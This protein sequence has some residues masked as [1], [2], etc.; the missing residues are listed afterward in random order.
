MLP[1]CE[2]KTLREYCHEVLQTLEAESSDPL[3]SLMKS[4]EFL[5]KILNVFKRINGSVG[6]VSFGLIIMSIMLPDV[7]PAA[8]TFAIAGLFTTATMTVCIML[9]IDDKMDKVQNILEEFRYC[10]C[11]YIETLVNPLNSQIVQC[12]WGGDIFEESLGSYQNA[13]AFHTT[14]NKTM[15]LQKVYVE[16]VKIQLRFNSYNCITR[17]NILKSVFKLAEVSCMLFILIVASFSKYSA[18]VIFGF[19]CFAFLGIPRKVRMFD[20]VTRI[21]SAR[22]EC[23]H[24]HAILQHMELVLNRIDY[25]ME[26]KRRRRNRA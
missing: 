15:I 20:G 13:M 23:Q 19:F 26:L 16:H 6:I 3:R 18:L 14:K 21:I 7:I 2:I 8:E 25:A 11:N 5:Q 22:S 9:L 17:T 10:F 12:N 4:V 1:D 24:F